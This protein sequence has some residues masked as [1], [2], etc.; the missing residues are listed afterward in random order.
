M[1]VSFSG[2]QHQPENALITLSTF[3]RTMEDIHSQNGISM[4]FI[5][6]VTHA[7]YNLVLQ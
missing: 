7:L 2:F 3:M 6:L 4:D 1:S 5:V